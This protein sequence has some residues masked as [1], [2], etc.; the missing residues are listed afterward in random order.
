MK[1]QA[2]E[3]S[4]AY[5]I[6]LDEFKDERGIF[7]SFYLRSEFI[8]QGIDFNLSQSCVSKNNKKNT[9][10][11]LHFQKSPYSQAKLVSCIRG[12]FNDIIVDIRQDSP[13]YLKHLI[14][15]LTEWNNKLLYIPENFA[16]GFQ[17]I[18]NDTWVLYHME[19][20]FKPDMA[21]G[22]RYNDP[23][24]NINLSDMDSMIINERDANYALL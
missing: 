7:S 17:T 19:N 21:T 24:L 2:L 20:D 6:S 8:K 9:F 16:H 5:L 12:S 4:G 18:I 3:L 14:I 23:K 10:R 15:E 13:T 22:L 1:F 11:G